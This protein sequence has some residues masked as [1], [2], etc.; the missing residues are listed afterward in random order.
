MHRGGA[1]FAYLRATAGAEVRDAR[2]AANWADVYATGMRRGAMHGYSL[3]RL[4]ADQANNFNTTVPRATDALPAVVMVDFTP[5]CPSRPE[6]AV[7]LD[8]LRRYITMVELHT[9]KPVLLKVAKPFDAAYRVTGAIPRPIWA[10]QNFFP[11]DYP[12]RPWK[13]WQANDMR[14]IDGVDGPV[15]WDVVAP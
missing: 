8:E 3:C 2:F 11:P 7:L 5:D 10:V 15:H 9:G 13:M 4:A 12:A 6:R 14:R 1:D